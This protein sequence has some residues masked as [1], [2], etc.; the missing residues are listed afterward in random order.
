MCR[1]PAVQQFRM[2]SQSMGL[3]SQT[4]LKELTDMAGSSVLGAS[5]VLSDEESAAKRRCW[6]TPGLGRSPGGGNGNLLQYSWLENSMDGGT[7]QTT[8]HR[9]AKSRI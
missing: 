4:Q 5:Q 6:L 1:W 3:Q 8:V 2:C 9:V 7:W